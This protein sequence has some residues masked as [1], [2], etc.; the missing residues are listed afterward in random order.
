MQRILF[1]SI[2][3]ILLSGFMK[4]KAPMYHFFITLT[5]LVLNLQ[6]GNHL[7]ILFPRMKGIVS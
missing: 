6:H 5:T 1:F 4:E 3:I 7:E 2:K